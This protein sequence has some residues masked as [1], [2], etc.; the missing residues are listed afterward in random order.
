MCASARAGRAAVYVLRRR[1][2]SWT[3]PPRRR[4]LRRVGPGP[5][6]AAHPTIHEL[7]VAQG[8]STQGALSGPAVDWRWRVAYGGGRRCCARALEVLRVCPSPEGVQRASAPCCSALQKHLLQT[9]RHTQ[10]T[11]AEIGPNL[12]GT[13]P[14]VVLAHRST[15]RGGRRTDPRAPDRPTRARHALLPGKRPRPFARVAQIESNSGTR[16]GRVCATFG[17]RRAEIGRIRPSLADPEPISEVG[18]N[19]ADPGPNLAEFR[20]R[21]VEIGPGSGPNLAG[22]GR[23]AKSNSDHTWPKWHRNAM[24]CGSCVNMFSSVLLVLLKRAAWAKM[25]GRTSAKQQPSTKSMRP[26]GSA[27]G[28][29][30][31]GR[32]CAAAIGTAAMS[33]VNTPAPGFGSAVGAGSGFAAASAR[34]AARCASCGEIHGMRNSVACGDA[35]APRDPMGCGDGMG[36]GDPMD[37]SDPMCCCDPMGGSGAMGCGD[38][39]RSAAVRAPA[40]P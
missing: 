24:R 9:L 3:P 31:A 34:C 22:F 5:Q 14:N 16:L 13:G 19:L 8:P 6:N 21:S 15:A 11:L 4:V 28:A 10:Q 36:S 17:R 37:C 32:A 29:E 2:R 18:L 25:M 38:I 20:P 33:L 27:G 39:L 35:I 23:I 30:A 26:G 40:S 1:R 12:V 7:R